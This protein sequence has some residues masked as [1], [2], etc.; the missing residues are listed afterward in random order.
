MPLFF[1]VPARANDLA[2]EIGAVQKQ[3]KKGF[4]KKIAYKTAKKRLDKWLS[5]MPMYRDSI[6]P[7][8]KIEFK[9]G[10]VEKVALATWEPWGVTYRLCDAP[11]EELKT[12]K[13][14]EVETI[15]ARNGEMLY[16]ANTAKKGRVSAA[17]PLLLVILGALTGI[18]GVVLI[19]LGIYLSAKRLTALKKNPNA[20]VGNKKTLQ[21]AL[22]LGIILLLLYFIFIIPFAFVF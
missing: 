5:A 1:V 3:V 20:N 8:A 17:G 15:N 2:P 11:E 7:C 18:L 14:E 21:V 13:F 4:L 19:G 6:S 9:N 12:A 16:G 22:T 10:K